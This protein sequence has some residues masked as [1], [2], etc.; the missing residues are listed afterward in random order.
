MRLRSDTH[1]RGGPW[2]RAC[3]PHL[4]P[5]GL[6][7][8]QRE[9]LRLELLRRSI[10]VEV[11]VRVLVLPVLN[12]HCAKYRIQARTVGRREPQPSPSRAQR[13]A[14]GDAPFIP[15]LLCPTPQSVLPPVNDWGP[16]L[17]LCSCVCVSLCV[18]V[19][20]SVCPS[21]RVPVCAAPAPPRSSC[22]RLA[23]CGWQSRRHDCNLGTVSV[24]AEDGVTAGERSFIVHTVC[25][26]AST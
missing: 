10:W 18:C 9:H 23:I 17:T 8:R 21:A 26:A 7:T 1:A 15:A 22:Y 5:V 6:D 11:E 12:G 16:P 25:C 3:S 2:L 20:V 14:R 24:T 19:S 13:N 4:L